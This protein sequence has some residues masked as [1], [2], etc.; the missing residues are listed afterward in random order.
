MLRSAVSAEP[1]TP[2]F[3][4]SL[5]MKELFAMAGGSPVSLGSLPGS[6]HTTP[7]SAQRKSS[8]DDNLGVSNQ[9]GSRRASSSST[10]Q[11]GSGGVAGGTSSSGGFSPG[12][13]APFT[14]PLAL[15][16]RQ[17]DDQSQGRRRSNEVVDDDDEPRRP[18]AQHIAHIGSLSSS[19]AMQTR[20]GIFDAPLLAPP[21]GISG[22]QLMQD[23]QLSSNY[24]RL[25]ESSPQAAAFPSRENTQQQHPHQSPSTAS[26]VPASST[27]QGRAAFHTIRSLDELAFESADAIGLGSSEMSFREIISAKLNPVPRKV[28]SQQ[29]PQQ[30]QQQPVIGASF[31]SGLG[32]VVTTLPSSMSGR[33]FRGAS[34][35]WADA[36]LPPALD[37]A[38][39]N[40]QPF[41]S[42]TTGSGLSADPLASIWSPITSTTGSTWTPETPSS[43]LS[44][45][46]DEAAR[47]RYSREALMQLRGL[48]SPRA[49]LSTASESN[50]VGGSN[51][52]ILGLGNLFL[53]RPTQSNPTESG[54]SIGRPAGS[55]AFSSMPFAAGMPGS[56]PGLRG[57]ENTG[58]GDRVGNMAPAA[59][60]PLP[61]HQTNLSLTDDIKSALRIGEA[62]ASAAA[63]I[64]TAVVD[65]ATAA[66]ASSMLRQMEQQPRFPLERLNHQSGMAPPRTAI[67]L[68]ATNLRAAGAS[69]I[70]QPLRPPLPIDPSIRQSIRMPS[71]PNLPSD[72]MPPQ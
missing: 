25:K 56:N 54:A 26:Q 22:E 35:T 63:A 60:H 34:S 17:A 64:R 48:A 68:A 32:S 16:R 62:D 70:G 33:S 13:Y 58:V 2:K 19:Y 14:P 67:R 47:T 30:Q 38:P 21:T 61:H 52:D 45:T 20:G 8:Q 65:A 49:S 4:Q 7:S 12:T 57:L 28:E 41:S 44:L 36:K 29:Q 39:S 42:L 69:A 23:I 40:A 15:D 18:M 9:S 72:V 6:V 37:N 66:S 5:D 46:S 59:A 71:N 1:S 53:P 3:G 31:N 10:G 55:G 11:G 27:A 51:D 24:H 43:S 50:A